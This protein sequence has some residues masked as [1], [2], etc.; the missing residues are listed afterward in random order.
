MSDASAMDAAPRGPVAFVRAG[1]PPSANKNLGVA[2]RRLQQDL[3]NLYR[4]AGGLHSNTHR[5]GVIYYFV[6]GY[7][8]SNDPD[9]GNVS[10]RIW[11]ALEGA[12]YDDDHVVR[13]QIAGLI[14]IGQAPSGDL[15]IEDID[16]ADV[17]SRALD[18]LLGLI[19][20]GVAHILYVELGHIRPSLFMFNLAAS[21]GE[22]S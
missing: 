15:A 20:E 10:K 16:L 4:E 5:Y 14:E 7:R 8:P 22:A 13:L 19:N 6:R 18:Q 3:A 11:D 12:A 17:P 1:R 21:G 2:G 9:A